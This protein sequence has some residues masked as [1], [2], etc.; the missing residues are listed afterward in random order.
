MNIGIG[1]NAF[2]EHFICIKFRTGFGIS[3]FGIA[4]THSDKIHV[5]SEV[6]GIIKAPEIDI[7]YSIAEI[8][9]GMHYIKLIAEI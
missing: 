8:R 5:H 3:Y 1:R 4:S 2:N 7:P 9:D 6:S